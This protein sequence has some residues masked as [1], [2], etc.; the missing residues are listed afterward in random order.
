MSLT[1]SS[2]QVILMLFISSPEHRV[3]KVS[4][5]DWSLSVVRLSVR[6]YVRQQLLKRTSP[7]KL[8]GQI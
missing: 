5:C 3:L 6:P 2:F 7:L 8:H 1:V 4:Y